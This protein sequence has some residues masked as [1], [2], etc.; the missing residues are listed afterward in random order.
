MERNGNGAWASPLVMKGQKGASYH[1]RRGIYP[2][3]HR[4]PF[5]TPS[6]ETACLSPRSPVHEC[7]V[8][9]AEKY[10]LLLP[11]IVWKLNS[12]RK[13]SA[14]SFSLAFE[15]RELGAY[16]GALSCRRRWDEL[17]SA[18]S[19][20]QSIKYWDSNSSLK[21]VW[22]SASKHTFKW[23][24]LSMKA[25]RNSF[26]FSYAFKLASESPWEGLFWPAVG[27]PQSSG[28]SVALKYQAEVAYVHTPLSQI[29]TYLTL[30]SLWGKCRLSIVTSPISSSSVSGSGQAGT[31]DFLAPH[32]S[33]VQTTTELH[34]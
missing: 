1:C 28:W 24:T 19:Y 14:S 16:K 6:P 33:W 12:G 3:H 17:L 2:W 30:C 4:T 22:W 29:G 20:C 21:Y 7:S 10:Q 27:G 18:A 8:K 31:L 32:T 26:M 23:L 9:E 15:T 11:D 25:E 5:L 13:Y 34:Q